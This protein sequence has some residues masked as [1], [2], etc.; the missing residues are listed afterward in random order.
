MCSSFIF[1]FSCFEIDVGKILIFNLFVIKFFIICYC[2][3]CVIVFGIKLMFLVF[4]I[5]LLFK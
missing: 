4:L 3:I 2:E 5:I 1:L